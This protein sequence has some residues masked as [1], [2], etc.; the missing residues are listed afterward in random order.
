MAMGEVIFRFL[1]DTKDFEAGVAKVRA[2]MTPL[3]A[4][5]QTLNSAL[6]VAKTGAVVAGASLLALTAPTLIAAKTLGTFDD[7]LRRIIALGGKEFKGNVDEITNYIVQLGLKYGEAVE[8]VEQAIIE[9]TK[10]GY[11]YNAIF[12]EMLEPT[13]QLAIAN[14]TDLAETATLANAAWLLWGK[15]GGYTAYT[16]L[17][18][19]HIAANAAKLDVLDL[20]TSFQYAGSSASIAGISF[21]EFLALAGAFS[22][23]EAEL[24]ATGGTF[25]NRILTGEFKP[26]NFETVFGEDGLVENG[27]INLSKLIEVISKGN[28]TYEEWADALGLYG[29]RS[30]RIL[31]QTKASADEYWRILGLLTDGHTELAGAADTMS[32]SVERLMEELKIAAFA[33][34]MQE[35]VL[36]AIK[37][38]LAGIVAELTKPG[39]VENLQRFILASASFVRDNGP[40]LVELL[41]KFLALANELVPAMTELADSLLWVLGFITKLGDKGLILLGVVY[42]MLKFMPQVFYQT[43]LVALGTQ[44]LAKSVWLVA[45]AMGAVMFG[46]TAFLTTSNVFVKVGAAVAVVLGTIAA[47]LWAINIARATGEA[48]SKP[49]VAP[50]IVGTMAAVAAGVGG[51]AAAYSMVNV[52]EAMG[53]PEM[54]EMSNLR[55]YIASQQTNVT[56]YFNDNKQITINESSTGDSFTSAWLGANV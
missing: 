22:Q 52:E 5:T 43:I 2:Q 38:A 33:P 16:M 34:L 24:G 50:W 14:Q 9:F 48:I 4:A 21:E 25:L 49:F 30:G 6:G 27:V 23:I 41:T 15:K 29:V 31:M 12:S 19:I 51:L 17:D 46:F 1:A 13:L 11:S 55:S 10:T 8:N 42:V 26:E 28:Y 44:T 54:P 56:N 45:G 7:N 47:A 20:Q 36:E 40:L 53:T 32:W 35:D 18:K 3:K 39:Y 37:V